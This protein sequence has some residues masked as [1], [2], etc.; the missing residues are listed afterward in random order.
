[1]NKKYM[2]KMSGNKKRSDKED[3][4]SRI[5]IIE[6]YDKVEESFKAERDPYHLRCKYILDKHRLS[7]KFRFD[8]LPKQA[9][10]TGF[11]FISWTRFL[12][13]RSDATG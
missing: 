8:S 11:W 4:P 13:V 9:D 1:M 10:G 12:L 5:E 7:Y 6:G 3:A 2:E